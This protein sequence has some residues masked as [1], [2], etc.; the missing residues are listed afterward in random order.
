MPLVAYSIC[1]RARANAHWMLV[2]VA[3]LLIADSALLADE[4]G[5][6]TGVRWCRGAAH[7]LFRVSVEPDPLAAGFQTLAVQ[8]LQIN[9]ADQSMHVVETV[10]IEETHGQRLRF[11]EL[12]MRPAGSYTCDDALIEARVVYDAPPDA[13]RPERVRIRISSS[14]HYSF[15]RLAE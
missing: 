7:G 8:I 5:V 12:S 2:A 10:P 4:H 15:R 9:G 3:S 1:R 11:S 13:P 14:G 6:L